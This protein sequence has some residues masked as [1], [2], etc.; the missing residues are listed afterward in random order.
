[1]KKLQ[2]KMSGVAPLLMHNERLADPTDPVARAMKEVTAKRKKTDSDYERLAFLEWTGSLYTTEPL[3]VAQDE[4]VKG[5][6]LAIPGK[7]IEGFLIKAGKQRRQGDAFKAGVFVEE[8][9][10]PLDIPGKVTNLNALW[11]DRNFRD[12]RG[13]KV[14]QAKVMRTR[15]RFNTWALSGELTYIPDV[16]NERDIKEAFEVAG[17]LCALGDYRPK[18]GRFEVEF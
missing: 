11:R 3:T 2:F 14:G 1:M 13:C 17:R 10:I 4:I 9:Y 7:M 16:I 15:P 8:E 18:F 6:V 5:G 12:V